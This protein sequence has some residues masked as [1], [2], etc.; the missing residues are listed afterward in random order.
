MLMIRGVGRGVVEDLS[1]V[2]VDFLW[3]Q[4]ERGRLLEVLDACE[5][6]SRVACRLLCEVR[7][8]LVRSL[9]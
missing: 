9:L 5:E 2:V 1:H 3:A 7:D 4:A 6:E 8:A